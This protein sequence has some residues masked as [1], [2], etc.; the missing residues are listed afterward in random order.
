VPTY[1][2]PHRDFKILIDALSQPAGVTKNDRGAASALRDRLM[3]LLSIDTKPKKVIKFTPLP[4]QWPTGLVKRDK[5]QNWAH[6]KP[7]E[8]K[9][10][11]LNN[12]NTQERI[13]NIL[14]GLI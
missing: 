11:E 13:D 2:G 8:K 5:K 7:R 12:S 14:E 6:H 3:E 10:V 4:A 9:L 1:T